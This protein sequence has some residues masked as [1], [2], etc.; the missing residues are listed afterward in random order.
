MGC[1]RAGPRLG[2]DAGATSGRAPGRARRGR[3]AAT[4][5]PGTP[6]R[7]CRGGLLAASRRGQEQGREAATALLAQPKMGR[8][9]ATALPAQPKESGSSSSSGPPKRAQ[10]KTVN[11]G[12]PLGWG[13]L[14]AAGASGPQA[15]VAQVAR[16]ALEPRVALEASPPALASWAGQGPTSQPGGPPYPP[17]ARAIQGWSDT[18]LRQPRRARLPRQ[19]VRG[20]NASRREE[21][22]APAWPGSPPAACSGVRSRRARARKRGRSLRA[23]ATRR[24]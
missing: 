12:F 14:T 9:A 3:E 18:Q 8:E 4:A 21:P 6:E 22:P 11:P 16:R 10:P 19:S 1:S 2:P 7:A 5:L 24:R 17:G 13:S 15:V 23:P 20:A